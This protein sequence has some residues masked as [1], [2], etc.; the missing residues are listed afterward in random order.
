MLQICQIARASPVHSPLQIIPQIF[1]R[2]QVWALAGPFEKLQS[3]CGEAILFLIWMS[4]L[5][6]CRAES[7]SSFLSSAF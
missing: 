6:R 2:I 3:F 7:L 4:A 5:G 1:N